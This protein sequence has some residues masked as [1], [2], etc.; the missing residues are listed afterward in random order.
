MEEPCEGER[1]AKTDAQRQL[2]WWLKKFVS[3]R[4]ISAAEASRE[5]GFGGSNWVGRMLHGT[6]QCNPPLLSLNRMAERLGQTFLGF[7]DC[8]R[9]GT[10]PQ[11]VAPPEAKPT[12][13]PQRRARKEAPAKRMLPMGK[14][15]T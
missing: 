14:I 15:S 11:R 5:L 1:R 8:V 2:L 10:I 4:E 13:K 12:R 9:N 3:E 6:K 7:M